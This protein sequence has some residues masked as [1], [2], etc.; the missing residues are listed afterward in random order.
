MILL[1]NCAFATEWRVHGDLQNLIAVKF[2][3]Q[4][5]AVILKTQCGPDKGEVQAVR[6]SA[7]QELK[8]MFKWAK[9]PLER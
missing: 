7:A 3:N 4:V 8:G 2:K 6:G 9:G 5:L 1:T